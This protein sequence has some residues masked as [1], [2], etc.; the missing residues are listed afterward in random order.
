MAAILTAADASPQGSHALAKSPGNPVDVAW[1]VRN[2]G[3]APGEAN[4]QL[5][6]LSEE[7]PERVIT[8]VN[9]AVAV[10]TNRSI[11][12]DERVNFRI[13]WTVPSRPAF[14]VL[15]MEVRLLEPGV[16]FIGQPHPFTVAILSTPLFYQDSA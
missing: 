8:T 2:T 13:Q 5:W 11:P 10:M 1:S 14:T 12:I 15:N 6:L 16:G 7:S 4:M 9:Q 3:D